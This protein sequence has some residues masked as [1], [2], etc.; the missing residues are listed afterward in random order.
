M[1]TSTRAGAAVS[2]QIEAS[3]QPT[4]R[5]RGPRRRAGAVDIPL[6]I[7]EESGKQAKGGSPLPG[8]RPSVRDVVTRGI[9]SEA[10]AAHAAHLVATGHRRRRLLGLV[11]D[12]RL[13]GAAGP[14]DGAGVRQRAARRLGGG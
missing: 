2:T 5:S 6:I 13:G 10:H 14:G 9:G 8:N 12:D 7:R 1:P 4:K 11:G 3:W